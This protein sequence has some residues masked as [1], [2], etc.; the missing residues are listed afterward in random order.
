MLDLSRNK[1]PSQFYLDHWFQLNKGNF[2]PTTSQ[3][4]HFIFRRTNEAQFYIDQNTHVRLFNIEID[5][6]SFSTQRWF[7][8]IEV[9]SNGKRYQILIEH[10][11]LEDRALGQKRLVLL[12]SLNHNQ[13]CS[14]FYRWPE[15]SNVEII[16]NTKSNSFF[17]GLLDSINLFLGIEGTLKFTVSRQGS[18]IRLPQESFS[19]PLPTEDCFPWSYQDV[20]VNIEVKATQD[21]VAFDFYKIVVSQYPGPLEE[22]VFWTDVYLITVEVTISD[23]IF[24]SYIKIFGNKNLCLNIPCQGAHE[25]LKEL[26]FR[27]GID[28]DDVLKALNSKVS[29]NQIIWTKQPNSK[30]VINNSNGTRSLPDFAAGFT[31]KNKTYSWELAVQDFLNDANFEATQKMGVLAVKS[32]HSVHIGNWQIPELYFFNNGRFRPF[33]SPEA[34]YFEFVSI[35]PP[36]SELE[37][38]CTFEPHLQDNMSWVE[39]NPFRCLIFMKNGHLSL[40]NESGIW[41]GSFSETLNRAKNLR[42]R[43]PKTL[44]TEITEIL[45]SPVSATHISTQNEIFP[46]PVQTCEIA[47]CF[48]K[49]DDNHLHGLSVRENSTS[50]SAREQFKLLYSFSDY[51]NDR[52]GLIRYY[53]LLLE[54]D[55]GR[56]I[57]IEL[58]GPMEDSFVNV[59][60]SWFGQHHK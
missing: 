14:G 31:L 57:Q 4:Y 32:L 22:S 45:V 34:W 10:L 3:G 13:W 49:D 33:D 38:K 27:F 2:V 50:W 23:N 16:L 26:N 21:K 56:H 47:L 59:I 24:S 60:N 46:S 15:F 8:D 44:A 11:V 5:G 36:V 43:H 29:I 6:F 12:D 37:L 20:P 18:N 52:G 28:R 39:I 55:N 30:L 53:S 17:G 51:D 41:K 58:S 35:D 25:F 40:S 48:W 42:S 1:Y 9:R 54:F 7:S 19:L